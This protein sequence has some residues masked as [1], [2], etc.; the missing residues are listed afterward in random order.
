MSDLEYMRTALE[1][2]QKGFPYTRPNPLVGAVIAWDNHIIASGYHQGYGLAHAEIQALND[3]Q[4]K[5]VTQ[6]QLSQATLY[7]TLEPCAHFGKTPPCTEAIIKSGIKRVV[8]ATLDPNPKVNGKGIQCLKESK[9][10]VITG[11]LQKEAQELNKRFFTFHEKQRPYVI[12][13]W[14]KT[15]DGFIARKDY[16]SKWITSEKSRHLVH[17]WRDQEMAV[18][19]GT[20]TAVHDNPKLTARIDNGRN[21]IRVLIDRTQR[22]PTSFLLFDEAAPVIIYNEEEDFTKNLVSLVK[23]SFDSS[24]IHTVLKDLCHRGIQS[25]M[26]EGGAILLNSFIELG[27]WDEARIFTSA[28][29]F[30][31]GIE[32]PKLPNMEAL[33]LF[34]DDFKHLDLDDDTLEVFKRIK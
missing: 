3:A 16:S 12:L 5:G 27:L 32:A 20:N 2:A 14:A 23:V 25:V 21:P 29:L 24:L 34:V 26:V 15:A 4:S 17:Q 22:V 10:D 30:N 33:A 19:V 28:K 7:V 18:M 8:V 9:I 6:A 1:L 31:E 13:K 11:C